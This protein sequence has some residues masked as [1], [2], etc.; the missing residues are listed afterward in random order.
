MCMDDMFAHIDQQQC[1]KELCFCPMSTNVTVLQQ[2][3]Q[4]DSS[5]G[6][7]TMLG[8]S[9]TAAMALHSSSANSAMFDAC[10]CSKS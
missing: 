2:N 5:M 8:Q 9:Q 1:H 7:D 3:S 6:C 10:T 4:Q